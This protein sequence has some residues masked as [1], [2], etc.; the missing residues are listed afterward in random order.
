MLKIIHWLY[1]INIFKLLITAPVISLGNNIDSCPINECTCD[2]DQSLIVCDKNIQTLANKNLTHFSNLVFHNLTRLN[3]R[4][5]ENTLFSTSLDS[6]SISQIKLVQSNTW[7]WSSNLPNHMIDNLQLSFTNDFII[8]PS[9][10]DYLKCDTL[11]LTFLQFQNNQVISLNNFGENTSIKHLVLDFQTII[12]ASNTQSTTLFRNNIDR[13]NK[14][15]DYNQ[16]Y[17][18]YWSAWYTEADIEHILVKNV[19]GIHVLDYKLVPNFRNLKKI[20]IVNTDLNEITETFS[21]LHS[22]NLKSLTIQKSNIE[23]IKSNVFEPLVNLEHLD[24]SFNRIKRFESQTFNGLLSLKTLRLN[25]FSAGFKNEDLCMLTYLPCKIDLQLDMGSFGSEE[26]CA[27]VYLNEI[28]F[29]R[30]FSSRQIN[31][32]SNLT[33]ELA[34]CFK[35][36]NRNFNE[37][38]VNTYSN[39]LILAD[40]QFV[41]NANTTTENPLETKK[42]ST[43]VPIFTKFF[44]HKYKFDQIHP[45][46]DSKV[47]NNLIENNK[48]ETS[49]NKIIDDVKRKNN[50]SKTPNKPTVLPSKLLTKIEDNTPTTKQNL[51]KTSIASEVST[52]NGPLEN[53]QAHSTAEVSLKP[54]KEDNL[55]NYFFY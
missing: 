39:D 45:Q 13:F 15:S 28:R 32:C 48:L 3:G 14:M 6:L 54:R 10:F 2:L 51:M 24:L 17:D 36:S 25:G 19:K 49:T 37:S 53:N 52:K 11:L 30:L 16:N 43:T 23:Y 27:A 35:L 1:L 7:A 9:S 41:R 42:V 12:N 31:P 21:Y 26:N 5:F 29:K 38:C 4:L 50:A 34:M 40:V 55:S 22:K 8:E 47:K 44:N 20:E 18:E 33:D 46:N